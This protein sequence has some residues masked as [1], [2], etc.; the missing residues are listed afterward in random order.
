MSK[1][2]GGGNKVQFRLRRDDGARGSK[3]TPPTIRRRERTRM[4]TLVALAVLMV[5]VG[6]LYLPDLLNSGG[7][8]GGPGGGP[9]G[10]PLKLEER[11]PPPMILPDLEATIALMSLPDYAEIQEKST[12]VER[13]LDDYEDLGLNVTSL[14]KGC[15][16]W[17]HAQLAKDAADPPLYE[18]Y[19][20]AALVREDVPL[21]K[22]IAVRG[23]LMDLT[24]EAIAGSGGGERSDE[25]WYRMTVRLGENDWYLHALAPATAVRTEGDKAVI[26]GETVHLVG[27]FTG[28]AK[29]PHVKQGVQPTPTMAASVVRP[30]LSVGSS[31]GM[32][33]AGSSAFETGRWREDPS[34][35]QGIDDN[36]PVLE[37][38]P[39]YYLLGQVHNEANWQEVPYPDAR[40]IDPLVEK[41]RT[42][43]DAYRGEAFTVD[44]RV[45]DVFEDYRVARDH[46]Y[47][48]QRVYRIRMWKFIHGVETEI[49]E[50]D[51]VYTTRRSEHHAFE[52]AVIANHEIGLDELPEPGDTVRATGRFLKVHGYPVH[53][54]PVLDQYNDVQRQSDEVYF[55]MYVVPDFEIVPAKQPPDWT[56]IVIAFV[57]LAASFFVSVAILIRNEDRTA[58]DYKK[59]MRRLRTTRHKLAKAGKLAPAD[60]NRFAERTARGRRSDADGAAAATDD[61]DDDAAMAADSDPAGTEADQDGDPAAA[62]RERDDADPDKRPGPA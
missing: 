25:L 37:K 50:G 53:A 51:R 60:R 49:R 29:L 56:P 20:P 54:D 57:L 41:V 61:G 13:F 46:P 47:N 52:L 58:D 36:R 44:G 38:R 11:K 31:G 55:Q 9:G 48:V 22:P 12:R 23:L 15:L 16:A 19:D 17:A 5:A 18:S 8:D 26:E 14:S 42:D 39:Y 3:Q 1:L 21:G 10:V 33:T 30:P 59:S 28:V 34:I 32:L 2:F 43:P 4:L 35:F 24:T 62:G 40:V 6:V 7:R 27:R 45:W